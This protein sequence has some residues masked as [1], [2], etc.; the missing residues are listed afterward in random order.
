MGRVLAIDHG[1][2]RTGLAVSDPL[3]II[4]NPLETV[5]TPKIFEWLEKY[6]AAESV[7]AI[8]VGYPLRLSGEDTHHTVPVQEFIAELQKRWP[9]IPVVRIDERL[10]SREAKA[11]MLESGMRKEKR[12]DKKMLDSISATLILQT[13]L[14]QH[15]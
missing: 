15:T 12:K 5:D 7:E 1:G 3:K 4:A 11:S 8:A 6:F 14:Q 10:T 13:Y 2:K 9:G